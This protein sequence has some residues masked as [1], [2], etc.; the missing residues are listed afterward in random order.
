MTAN[1]AAL[2]RSII[3]VVRL[4]QIK[5]TGTIST[6]A[7]MMIVFGARCR[8]IPIP[9]PRSAKSTAKMISGISHETLG[10]AKIASTSAATHMT[11][12]TRYI[13]RHSMKSG[14]FA[15]DMIMQ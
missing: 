3:N 13:F 12:D 7:K 5:N 4:S 14:T 15:K 8:A 9:A 11:N 6:E 2:M 10:A 1:A